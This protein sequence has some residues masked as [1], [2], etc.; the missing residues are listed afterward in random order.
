MVFCYFY[1]ILSFITLTLSKVKNLCYRKK[2]MK[3]HLSL[4]QTYLLLNIAII[5]TFIFLLP[6]QVIGATCEPHLRNQ[7]KESRDTQEIALILAAIRTFINGEAS[8]KIEFIEFSA[9]DLAAASIVRITT[10]ESILNENEKGR[11]R[12]D[13]I[14]NNQNDGN[15]LTGGTFFRT[16]RQTGL[17]PAFS[18]R[19]FELYK[20]LIPSRQGVEKTKTE[21]S[22]ER[23]G[24]TLLTVEVMPSGGLVFSLKDS[25]YNNI[26]NF[27]DSIKWEAI[28]DKPAEDLLRSAAEM[29]YE[30]TRFRRDTEERRNFENERTSPEHHLLALINDPNYRFSDVFSR[31]GSPGFMR[32][33][34]ERTFG[35][36]SN[37]FSAQKR[38]QRA[39][40]EKI[41]EAR[42][43][44]RRNGVRSDED[45]SNVQRMFT[46][47][48][49][50]EQQTT[51]SSLRERAIPHTNNLN[52]NEGM[53]YIL[54][55]GLKQNIRDLVAEISHRGVIDIFGEP[56]S[57]RRTLAKDILPD[58]INAT[59]DPSHRHHD[60]ALELIPENLRNISIHEL[61][62]IHAGTQF[63]GTD[64]AKFDELK[65]GL[66]SSKG[67]AILLV[68]DL[69]ILMRN[70]NTNENKGDTAATTSLLTSLQEP[71]REGRMTL[72]IIT[73]RTQQTQ[74]TDNIFNNRRRID[75]PTLERQELLEYIQ[76][77]AENRNTLS[78]GQKLFTPEQL[79]IL[80]DRTIYIADNYPTL[81]KQPG[82]TGARKVLDAV[83]D[84][85]KKDEVRQLNSDTD[86]LS[87]IDQ[88]ASYKFTNGVMG[89]GKHRQEELTISKIEES[90]LKEF[91]P[92]NPGILQRIIQKIIHP[93]NISLNGP[94]I[95]VFLGPPGTGK[96]TLLHQLALAFGIEVIVIEGAKIQTAED[97]I[98]THPESLASKIRAAKGLALIYINEANL[99]NKSFFTQGSPLSTHFEGVFQEG[100]F[101]DVNGYKVYTKHHH[102][103]LDMN[104][105]L[106]NVKTFNEWKTEHPNAT[107][108][109][110]NVQLASLVQS[111]LGARQ[112]YMSRALDQENM[113]VF[114]HLNVA[115]MTQVITI[116]VNHIKDELLEQGLDINFER[117]AIK[118][119]AEYAVEIKGVEEN[120]LA[121]YMDY[122]ARPILA[123]INTIINVLNANLTESIRDP[124]TRLDTEIHI[125]ASESGQLS[126]EFRMPD[127]TIMRGQ[128]D[129]DEGLF[130]FESESS[131]NTRFN[132]FNRNG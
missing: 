104:L 4:L 50:T 6:Y 125:L 119:L 56:N 25:F 98:G 122:G 60:L 95:Q 5:I 12:Y 123:R 18:Q 13:Q 94:L 83:F 34:G 93:V 14:S 99:I 17:F 77:L 70:T 79:T 27:L 124:R 106:E 8:S 53:T 91:V 131:P 109:Q 20:V 7:T 118:L 121:N 41:Q 80:T 3:T 58:L 100:V 120:A 62:D 97:I 89:I 21:I 16:L 28:A 32:R 61:Q 65:E 87:Y 110:I 96:T 84:N 69:S 38:I 37:R 24:E 59:R 86:I 116:R 15:N 11:V 48:R 42:P 67:K 130:S 63:R 71:I 126:I 114:E 132:F 92:T 74:L 129:L 30:E 31:L 111:E 46:Q 10:K 54:T 81:T 101:T 26:S 47:H 108:L 113:H 49:N 1:K 76:P 23:D 29:R 128:Y 35:R 45:P 103:F 117:T 127:G 112:A 22:F 73:N 107:Q 36:L 19:A 40:Y 43:E 105:S 66:L 57:G 55:E 90:I 75:M 52:K 9:R 2:I 39:L 115:G 88:I 82:L 44:E 33:I 72:V 68:T 51:E 85:A 64:S 78:D 102:F